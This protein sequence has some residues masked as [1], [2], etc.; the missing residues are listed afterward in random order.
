MR[1]RRLDLTRYG[2]FTAQHIDFGERMEGEPDLHLVYG[3][4]EA[5]KSTALSAFL[6]LL[7]GIEPRSKY[8]FLHAYQA[9][10]VGATLEIGGATHTLRRI[11]RP[12]NSLLD[13]SDQVV[14]EQLILAQLAGI[15][16][17]SY[18]AMFSLDD[19]TLEAGGENIL[20]SRG[21]LGELLFAATAGL[22]DLSQKLA[23]LR[24][25][26]EKFFKP[27]ARSTG[28]AEQK[29]KI[30]KLKQ[31]REALDTVAS[32]YAALSD[33]RDRTK[34]LYA[35][36]MSARGAISARRDEVQRFLAAL[37]RLAALRTLRQ[38]IAPLIDLPEA[39][40]GWDE[41]HE[42]LQK[43]Q[44][45][46]SVRLELAERE[47][48]ERTAEH[49][50]IIL[51]E[52]ALHLA[53]TVDGWTDARA[54]AITANKD[55]P[56]RQS[57][58]RKEDLAIAAI[59]GRLGH[60]DHADP[61]TL[62]P[63]ASTVGT[64]RALLEKRS[65]LEAALAAAVRERSKSTSLL[66]EAKQALS[67]F[68]A[69]STAPDASTDLLERLAAAAA[70]LQ[71]GNHAAR[72]R[73]AERSLAQYHAEAVEKLS[74][75]HPWDGELDQL[76]ALIVPERPQIEQ[77]K[78]A[79]ALWQKKLDQHESDAGRLAD[80]R[81]GLQ[82]ELACMAEIVGL[83]TDQEAASIRAAR[84]RA[85]SLHRGTLTP[86]SADD[87]EAALRRDDLVTTIRVRHE[88]EITK[89]HTRSQA[90]AAA[91][92]RETQAREGAKAAQAALRTLH[93]EITAT[94]S[95]VSPVLAVLATPALLEDWLAK[96]NEALQVRAR[97]KQAER[98]VRDALSD[99]QT[100][101]DRLASA[102][103]A[104][105]IPPAAH[106]DIETLAAIA[107]A[108]L[109]RAA[110]CKAFTATLRQCERDAKARQAEYDEA[111]HA[112][113][114][115]QNGWAQACDTALLQ[116][117][118][119]TPEMATVREILA[120]VANLGPALDRR[121]LL[122]DRIEK[123]RHDE[124]A[125]ARAIATAAQALG[126]DAGETPP[127]QLDRAITARVHAARTAHDL[128][129][130]KH[131]ELGQARRNRTA[132]QQ[133][134]EIHARQKAVMTT[135]FAVDSLT[136]VGTKLRDIETRSDLC[137]QASQAERDIID[138][139]RAPSIEQAEAH[140]DTADRAA[141]Q[142]ELTDLT[143]RYEVHDKQVQTLYAEY[144]GAEAQLHAVGGD[145][146]VAK[147]EEQRRTILLEIEEGARRYL[148]LRLGIAAADAALR[149]YRKHHRSAMMARAS[150]AF[151]TIS[152]NAYAGLASQPDRENEVL[153]AV[154][155]DGSSKIAPKLSKGTRFQLYLALRVAGYHEFATHRD[156][157]PFIADDIMETFDDF[158][159]E[160]TLRVFT[161]MSRTGQVIYL[162]HHRHLRDIAL[163][164]CPQIRLHTL[165]P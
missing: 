125:F 91:A 95:S 36:E 99:Q 37:P 62:I 28:L 124:Q 19:D 65:G 101:H 16:R 106:A 129:A 97:L 74:T 79:T 31:E 151:Q 119:P 75:L 63:P 102:L 153:V 77:W 93:Q 140:L 143:A 38:R 121:A 9:M 73:L 98:E 115:W 150:E 71:T 27:H 32:K 55:I 158:R 44:E 94:V 138:A 108:A 12:Q 122:V 25:E 107:Q 105:G 135:H 50:A 22:A 112:D 139:I 114:Q 164:A 26:A 54:R 83:A 103:T 104:A 49:D 123:M 149:A 5:G 56:E 66:D 152:Q 47:V 29:A 116:S 6:D 59:L 72:L 15:D 84:E 33:A 61:R 3:P 90:L 148:K 80:E 46:L 57:D 137:R 60:A 160:A 130:Q 111:A 1:L 165:Q 48:V 96:R 136:E 78:A 146:A 142:T 88:S 134:A 144:R 159:A 67:Q 126:I 17:E 35:S 110:E 8:N 157:L 11:K 131:Q 117:L 13:G 7:F 53:D 82:A 10:Q 40:A 89:L 43:E 132:L 120:T 34:S 156:P 113:A 133:K 86:A 100:A 51:D 68:Q 161:H 162:T 58:V 41:Q 21:D 118:G 81:A 18:R 154:C 64:L 147:I 70:S 52:T 76:A 163:A 2:K 128:K 4:N 109:R 69:D 155:A 23:T 39:P 24:E 30:A 42:T 45:E 14:S 127:L 85:W 141:L 92:A 145:A 20:A 87:F